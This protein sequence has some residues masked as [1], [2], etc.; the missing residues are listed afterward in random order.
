[1]K[2]RSWVFGGIVTAALATVILFIGGMLA[3]GYARSNGTVPLPLHV[4]VTF[5][6][7]AQMHLSLPRPSLAVSPDGR[8]IVYTANGGPESPQLWM[9]DL[10]HF[11]PRPIPGT[12]N[13]RMAT[14][15][16]DGRWIAFFADNQ[17]KKVPTTTGPV[18]VVCDVA[19]AFGATWITTEEI[20]FAVG[21]AGGQSRL[22]LWRV[23][24]TGGAPSRVT[25]EF[26]AYPEALPGGRRLLVTM[27]NTN[28]RTSSDLTIAV[29]DLQSGQV[30]R[31]LD[32]AVAARYASSGQLIYLRDGELLA[33]AFD[34][35]T[36]A[37]GEERVPVLSDIYFD[38]SLPVGN[39]AMS[40]SG[41]LAYVP[42]DDSHFRLGLLAAGADG[43]G[44]LIDERRHYG[45]ARVSPDGRRV[46]VLLRA[47][48]GEIWTIDLARSAF[49]RLTTSRRVQPLNPIWSHD[50]QYVFAA[51]AGDDSTSLVRLPSDGSGA[52][53]RLTTSANVQYPNAVTPDGTALIFTEQRRD[54]GTD[55]FL[56]SLDDRRT[57]P[58]LTSPFGESAAALSPD[59][60]WIAYQSNR[61][62]RVE[63]YV[64]AFPGMTSPVPVSTGG[65]GNPVWSRDGRRLYYN[66]GSFG[67]SIAV[68]DVAPGS[69]LQL[70]RPRRFGEYSVADPSFDV[71]PDGRLLLIT[72]SGTAGS[73]PELRI[74]VN[75]FD[76]VRQKLA[77]HTP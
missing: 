35:A 76:E 42:G 50:G 53:E 52:E 56:L 71:L 44:L 36:A 65:G 26:M 68:V 62:G 59:G 9:R 12:R 73:T 77:A 6:D 19:A 47:L 46:A 4:S 25:T 30:T 39:F 29:V 11:A 74:I 13:A 15:S 64:A 14:F 75:W 58:L 48:F 34:P 18:V 22:G 28:A 60:R 33:A 20:V 16:P 49:T 55:L 51:L 3:A 41:T 32:G 2:A 37:I 21:N 43:G 7:D 17:L 23:P 8:K 27:D 66:G 40:P 54:T 57:Q 38:P 5:P 31:V 10:D 69:T 72:G 61:S 24:A 45:T 67:A 1:V 70:S 63:V